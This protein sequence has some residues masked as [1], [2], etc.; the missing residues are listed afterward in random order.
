MSISDTDMRFCL[1]N[2][3]K[4]FPSNAHTTQNRMFGYT[5]TNIRTPSV[6]SGYIIDLV[7]EWL[8]YKKNHNFDGWKNWCAIPHIQEKHKQKFMRLETANILWRNI[9]KSN[10]FLNKTG[11]FLFDI[12]NEY[13][14]PYLNFL[15]YLYLLTGRYYNIK[16]QPICLI[17]E[18]MERLSYSN[19]V[20][21]IPLINHNRNYKKS[22]LFQIAFFYNPN[23]ENAMKIVKHLLDNGDNTLISDRLIQ[24]SQDIKKRISNGG[25]SRSYKA[26][27]VSICL[28]Y[29]YY[30]NFHFGVQHFVDKVFEHKLSVYFGISDK[31][32]L[33]QMI[34]KSIE[35]RILEEVPNVH[36]TID[37]ETKYYISKQTIHVSRSQRVKKQAMAN[38]KNTCFYHNQNPSWHN[39]GHFNKQNGDRY[40]EA[41][42]IVPINKSRLFNSSLDIVENIIPLCPNCHSKIHNADNKHI[43][44]LLNSAYRYIKNSNIPITQ[45]ILEDFYGV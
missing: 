32:K 44:E 38:F 27:A 15:M 31:Q 12:Q 16:Q 28:Y 37:N 30:N 13:G 8:K 35:N 5:T 29:V 18:I 45:Q 34:N 24:G 33:L 1:D 2:L 7:P 43:K 25:S 42:Y 17:S 20:A 10:S 22:R 26:D 36:N 23:S 3:G 9:D 11:A 41:H 6:V 21:D 19:I 14:K 40:L 4:K 39:E